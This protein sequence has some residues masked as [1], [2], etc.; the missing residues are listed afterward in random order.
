MFA[1][2]GMGQP[3]PPVARYIMV[4]FEVVVLLNGVSPVGIVGADGLMLLPWLRRTSHAI[5]FGGH[6]CFTI[7][8]QTTS[9]CLPGAKEAD[10]W[11]GAW[12]NAPAT[13]PLGV[14]AGSGLIITDLQ[15]LARH[16]L[17]SHTICCMLSLQQIVIS[18]L[19]F[20]C[21]QWQWGKQIERV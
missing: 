9:L 12:C 20:I 4:K 3:C 5:V 7:N 15:T 11:S 14:S 17:P 19:F 8:W 6:I 1:A 13:M 21:G 16:L 18:S 2:F 10:P